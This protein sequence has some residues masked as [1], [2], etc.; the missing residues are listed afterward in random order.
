MSKK[1]SPFSKRTSTSTIVGNLPPDQMHIIITAFSQIG[2][3]VQIVQ[4]SKNSNVFALSQ[5]FLGIFEPA[6][7][8]KIFNEPSFLNI[9]VI[10]QI[11]EEKG[12]I[13]IITD[14][15]NLEL[16]SDDGIE[17]ARFLY[18]NLSLIHFAHSSQQKPLVYATSN[19]TFPP[20]NPPLSLSQ[21]FQFFYSGFLKYNGIEYNHYPVQY[22][23]Y[24]LS[25]S[26][27]MFDCSR[28]P[29]AA[30]EC[31]SSALF[32]MMS[33]PNIS[34][35]A[36]HDCRFTLAF[37]AIA[38]M[39]AISPKNMSLIHVNNCGADE[40]SFESFCESLKS[41]Q[42]EKLE[43][44]DI[45]DNLLENDSGLISDLIGDMKCKLSHLGISNCNNNESEAEATL[46]NL[47]E[48]KNLRQMKELKIGG[49]QFTKKSSSY[50]LSFL[51]ALSDGLTYIDVSFNNAPAAVLTSLLKTKQPLKRLDFQGIN[52]EKGGFNE[53]I[54]L[55]NGTTTLTTL[56]LSSSTFGETM[57]GDIIKELAKTR[58]NCELILDNVI[59]NEITAI[60]FVRG[61]MEC[62][63]E[64]FA[65]ISIDRSNMKRPTQMLISMLLSQMQ[66]L[67][68]IS[69]NDFVEDASEF[70]VDVLQNTTAKR[71]NAARN[72]IS[73]K[74]AVIESL[75]NTQ[76]QFIDFSTNELEDSDIIKAMNILRENKKLRSIKVSGNSIE[77]YETLEFIAQTAEEVPRCTETMFR[78]CDDFGFD[79]YPSFEVMST[80]VDNNR[81]KEGL[82]FESPIEYEGINNCIIKSLGVL[83]N[84]INIH[85][86]CILGPS[87]GLQYPFCH[88]RSK[89][90]SVEPKKLQYG[91]PIDQISDGNSEEPSQLVAARK[92][93][94]F[95]ESEEMEELNDGPFVA[96]SPKPIINAKESSSSDED[97]N[98]NYS[99]E[100]LDVKQK[101]PPIDESEMS[102][103]SESDKNAK[104]F[105]SP[106]PKKVIMFSDESED[107][108]KPTPIRKGSNSKR[109]VE[110]DSDESDADSVLNTSLIPSFKKEMID[111]LEEN[112]AQKQKEQTYG[113]EENKFSTS[114][115]PAKH[116]TLNFETSE[117]EEESSSEDEKEESESENNSDSTVKKNPA[118]REFK[119]IDEEISS[120]A[121]AV[122]IPPPPPQGR[123]SRIPVLRNKKDASI[124]S[125][126]MLAFMFAGSPTKESPKKNDSFDQNQFIDSQSDIMKEEP[127]PSP[128]QQ[129]PQRNTFMAGTSPKPKPSPKKLTPTRSISPQKKPTPQR[130]VGPTSPLKL[131]A[132]SPQKRT[133]ISPKPE[134]KKNDGFLD[135]IFKPPLLN[136]DSDSD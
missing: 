70:I 17:F 103:D 41:D 54:A 123:Q 62:P 134:R 112:V 113:T 95:P 88:Q 83:M 30:S 92:K 28:I 102:S 14:D 48:N 96:L 75:K 33:F 71:V 107:D 74:E 11:S 117:Y 130:N 77:E 91:L 55:I 126:S 122:E 22:F 59:I 78:G 120:S 109:F 61:L 87:I 9:L 40:S 82:F 100:E 31:L 106:K 114:E 38:Q 2:E 47:A 25:N 15:T 26:I 110:P 69:I 67:Q 19:S 23:H 43:Y 50:F 13:K 121:P 116:E 34:C 115:I 108:V 133:P 39:H 125:P 63:F 94:I 105:A 131:R 45:S 128:K 66:K 90:I 127:I 12:K 93:G 124:F 118:I 21:I 101:P 51:Q 52:F 68:E 80:A 65:K 18:R 16:D 73:N 10:K 60:D 98:N 35:F 99:D 49:F 97:N 79:S 86:H 20:F 37:Q 53:L 46:K 32:S 57:L 56:D 85:N 1:N 136:S 64:N 129:Q 104:M 81:A 76:V 29:Q 135:L 3:S 111:E 72:T 24:L 27:P 6:S 36:C 84:D 44:F 42:L 89:P 7:G 8:R 5:H 4:K 132:T 119:S 58:N